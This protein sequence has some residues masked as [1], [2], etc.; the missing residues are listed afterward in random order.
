V[1]SNNTT[2]KSINYGSCPLPAA[3]DPTV[4]REYCEM[5]EISRGRIRRTG[6]LVQVLSNGKTREV[7]DSVTCPPG[8]VGGGP[9]PGPVTSPTPINVNSVVDT[10]PN[11]E[12]TVN[13]NS[14]STST[15]KYTNNLNFRGGGPIR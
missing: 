3:P 4:V 11:A 12:V 14:T 10:R 2:S 6:T 7:T 1:F 15:N 8:I 5:I 13:N 9:G